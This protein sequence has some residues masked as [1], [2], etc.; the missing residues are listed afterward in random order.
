MDCLYLY[1]ELHAM[2]SIFRPAFHRQRTFD[3]FVRICLSFILKEDVTGVTS[4]VRTGFDADEKPS[5]V[6]LSLQ[7][8]FRSKAV[9]MDRMRKIWASFVLSLEEVF[10]EEQTGRATLIIDGVK[11]PREGRYMPAVARYHQESESM[12][13]AEHIWGH[14]FGCIGL[15]I[16]SKHEKL[17]YC[18]LGAEI[19]GGADTIRSWSNP[20]YKRETHPMQLFHKAL[21]VYKENEGS[22]F[23]AMDSYFLTRNIVTEL[24]EVNK[25]VTGRRL[26][27]IT[28]CKI[29]VNAYTHP[30]KDNV[31]KRGRPK[32]RGKKIKLREYFTSRRSE[33]KKKKLTIYGKEQDV[34]YLTTDLLWGDGLYY[35]MRFVLVILESGAKAILCCTDTSVP[36]DV[37]IEQFSYRWKCEQA[38]QEAKQ[39]IG[40]FYSHFWTPSMPRLNHFRKKGDA[41][42]IESVMDEHSRQKIIDTLHATELYTLIGHIAQGMLQILALKAREKGLLPRKWLRT[43]SNAVSSEE[44]VADDLRNVLI[45]GLSKN[46]GLGNPLKIIGQIA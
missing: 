22:M 44:T 39:N 24:D 12:T 5:Y 37:I 21:E 8:F 42:P 32:K 45:N 23:L 18:P 20:G 29:N 6:Y 30:E 28:K 43:Y 3:K 7:R 25:S 41:D 17:S 13:K 46:Y 26:D 27:C 4:F 40:S 31:G 2:L 14:M 36:P 10:I 35:E 1:R 16:G 15:L 19:E 9:D 34:E 33:F 11:Q 38:F